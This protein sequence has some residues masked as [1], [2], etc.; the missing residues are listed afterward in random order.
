MATFRDA[1]QARLK[2]KMTLS[3]YAWY[4]SSLVLPDTD[5]YLV[6]VFVSKVDN[7]VRK[8]VPPV[9]NGVS[10]KTEADRL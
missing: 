10:I 2:L 4:S 1:A 6:V 8:A 7:Q 3:Q 9:I 5:G